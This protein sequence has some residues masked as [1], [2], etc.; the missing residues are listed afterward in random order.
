MDTVCKRP[1][2][3]GLYGSRAVQPSICALNSMILR[4]VTTQH[5]SNNCNGNLRAGGDQAQI[6]RGLHATSSVRNGDND[7]EHRSNT[8]PGP[9]VSCSSD[10]TYFDGVN[11]FVCVDCAHEWPVDSIDEDGDVISEGIRCIDCL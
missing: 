11:L 8:A 4:P 7:N 6:N 1:L 2:A 10:S 5:L 3:G 9:C